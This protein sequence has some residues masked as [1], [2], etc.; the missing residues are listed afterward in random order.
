MLYVKYGKNWLHGF[1]GDVVWK[2]WHRTDD[3]GQQMPTYTI[4]SPMCL[5][6]R[7]A[8][9]VTIRSSIDCRY[10]P[11]L[12]WQN[13]LAHMRP[14]KARWLARAFAVRS[15]NEAKVEEPSDKNHVSWVGSCLILTVISFRV[16]PVIC[17]IRVFILTGCESWHVWTLKEKLC[18][19]KLKQVSC[20]SCIIN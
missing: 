16:I 8:K 7:W 18:T 1:K 20:F 17:E 4:S 13:E 3:E 2:S 15:H 5:R 19:S 10:G 9:N 6:L 12:K 14:V 11:Q